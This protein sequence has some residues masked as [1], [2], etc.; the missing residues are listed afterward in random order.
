ML[1]VTWIATLAT[2][3]VLGQLPETASQE[4]EANTI[5]CRDG[6]TIKSELWRIAVPENRSKDHSRQI[7]LAFVRFKSPTPG[8]RP[9]VFFLAGG[10]GGSGITIIQRFVESGGQR[11]FDLIGGDI[12]AID[13]RGVGLSEPNLQTDT[14]YGFSPHEPGNR[15]MML[16]RMR[17]ICQQE[18]A[19]WRAESVDLCGYNTVESADDVNAIRKALGY[20]K[21]T[22]WGASYGT[23]LAMATIRR[24]EDHISHA[25]LEGPEG[26][27]HTFKLPVQS[28]IAL[29]Q[30]SKLVSEDPRLGSQIPDMIGMLK[31]VLQRL[32]V[33]PVYVDID[34]KK[35]G[36][37]KFDL[38]VLIAMKIGTINGS[39]DKIPAIVKELYEGQF[40]EVA[41]E[42]IELRRSDGIYSA[43][44]MMMDC[45]SGMTPAREKLI[46]EQAQEC[47]LGDAANWP[48]PYLADAWGANDLG[49]QFRSNVD[50]KVAVLFIV[51]NM[52]SRTPVSNAEELMKGFSN[53]DLVIVDNVGHNDLPMGMPELRE[54]W[55][56]FLATGKAVSTSL[57]APKI[58]FAL[59]RGM[60]VE[61]P[62]GAIDR[63]S[64][65]LAE[66][67]G[68]Y[69]FESG[70]V[71]RI[72]V[73]QGRLIGTLVG[74][75]DFDL[76]PKSELEYFP[77]D[78]HLPTIAFEKDK[79]GKVLR[80][81]GG[82][83]TAKR[84]ISNAGLAYID[85][86]AEAL[87]SFT[88]RYDFN[89]YG[90]LNIVRR[91]KQLYAQ[92][93]GQPQLQVRAINEHSIQ[94]IA[95][96]AKMIFENDFETAVFL[97]N[98]KRL[99]VKKLK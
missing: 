60:V 59:P 38:Q 51:G 3:P 68:E 33:A 89:V 8:N 36:V 29:Q 16:Q 73:G 20:D 91:G 45:S 1:F 65:Q 94:W 50:S 80:F 77:E 10:P 84:L 99:T 31:T 87:D 57:V 40:D 95:S 44:S 83:K 15:E 41:R 34:G 24:H 78:S 37:S 42:L 39:A 82:N 5:E 47:L 56:K 98:D 67:V 12:V 74:K 18:A 43:M 72:R 7:K 28:E 62:A 63:T 75:G 23:H 92:F 76:W 52:D 88:G 46:D 13:Q 27:D 22:I 86:T 19:K 53:S 85:L 32:D 93:P 14:L 71:F 69:R 54:I 11:F 66:F 90:F 9:P 35:I 55:G 97:Q 49:D 4:F 79:S 6:S 30:I 81:S 26:L 64:E 70:A 17:A 96:D 48:T 2:R 25:L 58:R 61:R 21:I